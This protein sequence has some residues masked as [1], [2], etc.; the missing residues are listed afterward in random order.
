MLFLNQKIQIK[1]FKKKY[2]TFLIKEIIKLTAQ[3][4]AELI[5]FSMDLAPI[6]A[7]NL[8]P[9]VGRLAVLFGNDESKLISL[10][11]S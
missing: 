1:S 4:E 9:F 8:S 2:A 3:I 10:A 11:L 6:E 7:S 5:S